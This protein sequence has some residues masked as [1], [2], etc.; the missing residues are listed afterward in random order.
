MFS[1]IGNW[2]RPLITSS[3]RVEHI[4]TK[5]VYQLRGTL[6]EK[7]ASFNIPYREDQ[8]LFENLAVFD[9]ESVCVEEQTYKETD[10][11]KWIGKRF[12]FVKPNTRTRFL[13]FTS[14]TP[15]ILF[16]QCP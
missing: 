5:N 12:D 14:W 1:K 11:T 8:K 6:F 10:T 3:E 13:Q 4:Y 2:E 9:S 7:L 16:Y 15:C